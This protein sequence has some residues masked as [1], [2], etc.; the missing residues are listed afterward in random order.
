MSDIAAELRAGF[1]AGPR[2]LAAAV[3]ARYAE[4]VDI[5]H[6]PP[7]KMDGIFTRDELLAFGTAELDACYKAMPDVRQE[8][9]VTTVGDDVEMV[10]TTSGTL[11]D[12]TAVRV[13]TSTVYTVQDD[14]IVRVL[15]RIDPDPLAVLLRILGAGG[16]ELPRR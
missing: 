16:F 6:E 12:G 3:A 8:G 11:A 15:S 4:R 7:N 13:T 10:T 1:A 2:E 5:A 9:S 14:R